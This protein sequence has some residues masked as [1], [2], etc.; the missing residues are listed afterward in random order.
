MDYIPKLA[1][2]TNPPQPANLK[3][4]SKYLFQTSWSESDSIS[5]NVDDWLANESGTCK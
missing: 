2:F 4:K 5:E 3:S 1:K